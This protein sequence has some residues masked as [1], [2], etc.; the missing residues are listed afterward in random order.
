MKPPAG[1]L[2]E[3]VIFV[4]AF[5]EVHGAT[6]PDERR[7]FELVWFERPGRCLADHASGH[8]RVEVADH[9]GEENLLRREIDGDA[10]CIPFASAR[11]APWL[12]IGRASCRERV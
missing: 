5:L 2:E 3:Q 9:V 6:K 1:H 10:L 12:E 11:D 4:A 8:V 7:L